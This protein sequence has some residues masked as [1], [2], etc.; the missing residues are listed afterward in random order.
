MHT[1]T[2]LGIDPQGS[3]N[4][5][6]RHLHIPREPE[7][8]IALLNKG[9]ITC[10]DTGTINDEIFVNVTG[11]GFDAHVLEICYRTQKRLYFTLKLR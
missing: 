8:A 3:G 7:R 10:I 5:F 4:G 2:A 9:K 6:A 11:A 1:S